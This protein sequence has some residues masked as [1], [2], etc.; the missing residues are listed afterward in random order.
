MIIFDYKYTHMKPSENVNL[1]I[2]DSPESDPKEKYSRLI[3]DFLTHHTNIPFEEN[4]SI[5]SMVESE[6][7]AYEPR[8]FI[9][10]DDSYVSRLLDDST[11]VQDR[12]FPDKERSGLFIQAPF[13][14]YKIEKSA[15]SFARLFLYK[16]ASVVIIQDN[17]NKLQIYIDG[18]EDG[19]TSSVVEKKHLY[20]CIQ[21]IIDSTKPLETLKGLEED[22]AKRNLM[23][24]YSREIMGAFTKKYNELFSIELAA[25]E[26]IE[27][28][29]SAIRGFPPTTL[30]KEILITVPQ[31]VRKIAFS[32]KEL[33]IEEALKELV[34]TV[35]QMDSHRF[36]LHRAI[37][38]FGYKFG[39]G[40]NKKEID[41]AIIIDRCPD[42]LVSKGGRRIGLA[43]NVRGLF[44]LFGTESNYDFE[45]RDKDIEDRR[46]IEKICEEIN[47]RFGRVIATLDDSEGGT[48]H[49]YWRTVGMLID[50]IPLDEESINEINAIVQKNIDEADAGQENQ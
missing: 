47:T 37:E 2:Q 33:T 25:T 3:V 4:N 50:S 18:E 38:Y 6:V 15:E 5:H 41:R 44:Y 42:K 39:G 26:E 23:L 35:T 11:S 32:L 31:E 43:K 22:E 46:L 16:R 14:I 28:I 1:S 20:Q 21:Q 45:N 19:S 13:Y 17:E 12:N 24:A 36:D 40:M 7:G 34:T 30:V 10:Y 48:T 9:K 49:T 27:K 8:R 29:R